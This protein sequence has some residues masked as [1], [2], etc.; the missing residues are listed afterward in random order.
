MNF[1]RAKKHLASNTKSYFNV[2]SA[3]YARHFWIN[4]PDTASHNICI[5]SLGHASQ[6]RK[7]MKAHNGDYSTGVLTMSGSDT[8]LIR[9]V[10]ANEVLDMKHIPVWIWSS[11]YLLETHIFV[12]LEVPCGKAMAHGSS[13]GRAW[14]HLGCQTTDSTDVRLESPRPNV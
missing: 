10:I 4:F 2:G 11:V 8:G 13:L 14:F 5:F 7:V 9:K 12:A 6:S 3:F 1:F